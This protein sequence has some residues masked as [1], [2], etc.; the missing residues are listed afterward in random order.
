MTTLRHLRAA[1][2]GLLLL[3][4]V[5]CAA[6]GLRPHEP[7]NP[8]KAQTLATSPLAIQS[9]AKLHRFTV[10]LADTQQQR[11]I[12][13]MHRTELA[14]DRGMLF[15]FHREQMVRFWMRNTFI[16]LDMIFINTNG[17]I[18]FIV[19]NATP[20]SDA[21]RGPDRPVQA[22]LEL[23]GGRAA[24]LGLKAGDKVQH[25]AFGTAP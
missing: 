4:P 21:P 1:L 7:L 22:V 18:A 5:A 11:D 13:M 2:L 15:D 10:E 24:Q 6:Q 14:P 9:G 3:L 23:A 16:P 17:E 8:A 20:H 25:A 12:G 19:E